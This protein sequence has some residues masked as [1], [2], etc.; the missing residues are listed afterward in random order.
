MDKKSRKYINEVLLELYA[1]KSIVAFDY[2]FFSP[3][4]IIRSF[5]WYFTIVN[6]NISWLMQKR[7]FV[8][9]RNFQNL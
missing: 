2:T 3:V 8:T 6:W 9:A 7:I 4:C 5:G 1:N